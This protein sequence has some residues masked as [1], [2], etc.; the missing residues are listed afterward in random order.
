[1]SDKLYLVMFIAGSMGV[2][3]RIRPRWE[4][5]IADGYMTI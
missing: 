3:L 1:M 2:T 5:G 4:I